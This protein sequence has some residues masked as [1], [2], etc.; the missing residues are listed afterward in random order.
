MLRFQI[1]IYNPYDR[2]ARLQ[3]AIWTAFPILVSI[4]LLIHNLGVIWATVTGGFMYFGGTMFLKQIVRDR[5]KSLEPLLFQS[6][7]GKPSVAMLRH[8][9][10]RLEKSTKS[11]YRDFLN[12]TVPNVRLS[13]E[14]NEKKFPE[15][16]DKGYESANSWL[17]A[18]TRD[19]RRFNLL[20]REN[21]NYGFR[22]NILALKLWAFIVDAIV[23][24]FIVLKGLNYWTGSFTT[25]VQTI[26]PEIWVSLMIAIGHMIIFL[27]VIQKKWV[28]LAA[29]TYAKTLL[30]A[31]DELEQEQITKN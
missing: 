2:K 17:L 12:R 22:R 5:G 25:T 30:S 24:I 21:I 19:T 13:S 4:P 11:R 7:G 23:I 18:Q 9:D 26:S 10:S 1:S 27:I 31:C 20:F 14:A 6:W 15:K 8:S 16:A 29:E 28:R 3:P